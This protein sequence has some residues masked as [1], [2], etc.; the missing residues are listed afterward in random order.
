M[1]TGDKLETA[2]NIGYSSN[3][4]KESDILVEISNLSQF[5]EGIDAK[6]V[7]QKK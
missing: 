5:S 4:V 2:I 3:L 7:T 1:L 6:R